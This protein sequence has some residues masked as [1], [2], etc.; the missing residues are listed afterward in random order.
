MAHCSCAQRAS[1]APMQC[2][3]WPMHLSQKGV[4][5]VSCR[6][7]AHLENVR[8]SRSITSIQASG[9]DAIGRFQRSCARIRT[10]R[11]AIRPLEPNPRP[12]HPLAADRQS[13]LDAREEAPLVKV[14][15]CVSDRRVSLR[16][17]VRRRHQSATGRC[18]ARAAHSTGVQGP[19]SRATLRNR[20]FEPGPSTTSRILPRTN[21]MVKLHAQGLGDDRPRRKSRLRDRGPSGCRHEPGA[22]GSAAHPLT[23]RT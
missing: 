15:V 18:S 23:A 14:L 3:I 12:V 16:H 9:G 17:G 8:S 6:A 21:M 4:P 22:A 1:P 20:F 2:P 7:P 11:V 5:A 13:R 10:H 19:R